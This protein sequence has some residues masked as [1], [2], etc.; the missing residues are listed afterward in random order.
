MVSALVVSAGNF[1]FTNPLAAAVSLHA[2]ARRYQRARDNSDAAIRADLA[3]LVR[4]VDEVEQ[5]NSDFAVPTADGQWIGEATDTDDRGKV[6]TIL[7]ARTFISNEMSQGP[8][9]MAAVGY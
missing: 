3:A 9:E 4:S 7:A 5:A 6:K 1:T 2:L 8:A